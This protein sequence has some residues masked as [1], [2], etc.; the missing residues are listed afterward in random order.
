MKIK[1]TI[2]LFL[3]LA[4]CPGSIFTASSYGQEK[5]LPRFILSISTLSDTR[6]PLYIAKELGLFA[7][8]GLDAEIVHIRGA[9]INVASLMAGEIHMAVAAGNVAIAAAARGAPI[10]IVATMGP[11][12]Y[13]LVARPAIASIQDLKGKIFG[14]SSYGTGDYFALRRLLLKLGLI[15]EK[16]V[17][18]IPTGSTTSYERLNALL[19]GKVDAVV[20]TQTSVQRMEARGVKLNVLTG[21]MEQ[22]IDISGGEFFTTRELV[23]T[24]PGSIK[25]MLRAFSEAVRIGRENKEI[26]HRAVGKTLREDDPKLL[27]AFYKRNYFFEPRPHNARPVETALEGTIKDLTASVPELKGR[28][29]SEFVDATLLDQVEKEGFFSWAKP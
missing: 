24:R 19:A 20:T 1:F 11:T 13:S 3:V 18:L 9:A 28:R 7:K 6:A 27:A 4:F 29:A 22:G 14:I 23:K 10:V 15:P 21:S 2:R 16:D 8:Y 25:A 26:F 12:N 5:K 17:T